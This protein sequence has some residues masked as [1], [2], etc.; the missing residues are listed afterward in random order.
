VTQQGTHEELVVRPGYYRDIAAVQL[1][2]DD[3]PPP[4]DEPSH[5]KRVQSPVRV[6]AAQQSAEEQRE[7]GL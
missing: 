7:V 1:Y 2:G 6:E 3:G 5:M 4:T